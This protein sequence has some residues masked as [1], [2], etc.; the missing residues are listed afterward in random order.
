MAI[1]K[2]LF[3]GL[4]FSVAVYYALLGGEYSAFDMWRLEEQRGREQTRLESLR[5]EVDS[6]RVAVKRLE[7]DL[8]TVERVAR[9]QFGMI[10]PGEVLYRFV[11]ASSGPGAVV[12]SRSSP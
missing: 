5:A 1:R 12:D 7:T 3:R 11:E 9:E 4:L 8:P 6:L 10:R 2:A